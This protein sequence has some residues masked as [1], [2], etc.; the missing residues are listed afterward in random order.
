MH[1][2][3]RDETIA[4]LRG[5]HWY[6]RDRN[7]AIMARDIAAFAKREGISFTRAC[8]YHHGLTPNQLR[9]YQ[10]ALATEAVPA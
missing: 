2:W 3:T 5:P 4:V 1:P 6:D 8:L 10:A 9:V 7:I